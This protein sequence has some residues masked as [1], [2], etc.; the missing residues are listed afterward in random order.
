[1]YL[2]DVAD[3]ACNGAARFF[4]KLSENGGS[5]TLEF[6]STHPGPENRVEDINAKADEIGCDTTAGSDAVS[7]YEAF[8]ALLAN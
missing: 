1:M 3:Y 6:L 8:K 4:E 5:G 7:D 2:A